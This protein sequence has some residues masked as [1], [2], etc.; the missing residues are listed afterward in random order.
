MVPLWIRAFCARLVWSCC[1]F[2]QQPTSRVQSASERRHSSEASP[3]TKYIH[4]HQQMQL[5]PWLG[6]EVEKWSFPLSDVQMEANEGSRMLGGHGQNSRARHSLQDRTTIMRSSTHGVTQPDEKL[7]TEVGAH[8]ISKADTDFSRGRE[9]WSQ[10]I[11]L[12]TL[13]VVASKATIR[14][15]WPHVQ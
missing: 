2:F 9:D 12:S 7:M 10:F 13:D 11:E 3:K 15:V 1:D 5:S 6:V 14:D 4:T 8:A